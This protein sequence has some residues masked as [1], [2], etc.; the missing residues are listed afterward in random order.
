VQG[1]TL[2][3]SAIGTMNGITAYSFTASQLA[4]NNAPPAAA[5]GVE[6]IG[7]SLWYELFFPAG[8]TTTTTTYPGELNSGPLDWSWSYNI[9]SDNCVK[10]ESWVDAQSN[11]G[12][13]GT[14]VGDITAPALASSGSSPHC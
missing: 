14:G 2:G 12:G 10:A 5:Q 4:G 6:P 3:D 11:G 9:A 13:Q 7:T 1:I 8:A